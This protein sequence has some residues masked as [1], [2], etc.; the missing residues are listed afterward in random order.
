MSIAESGIW[1][2]ETCGICEVSDKITHKQGD[3]S[4]ITLAHLECRV[5]DLVVNMEC[6]TTVAGT[7]NGLAGLMS[8]F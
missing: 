7:I 8:A 2:L 3:G 4:E 1:V 6:E 5:T